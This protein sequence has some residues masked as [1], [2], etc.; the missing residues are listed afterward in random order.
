MKRILLL[1]VFGVTVIGMLSADPATALKTYDPFRIEDP[2]SPYVLDLS[3]TDSRR[4]R[5]IPVRI[6]LPSSKEPAAVALFSHGLGGSCKINAF[7]GNHWAQRGYAAVFVQ[8]PGSDSS[9]WKDVPPDKRMAALRKAA[10]KKNFILRAKDIPAVLN[11]LETWNQTKDHTFYKRFDCDHIGMSGHSFGAMTTQAVSGQAVWAGMQVFTDKRI[12]AAI[13]FSPSSPRSGKPEKAFAKVSIPWMLMTG[14][15]DLAA[16]GN[17]DMESRL[18]VFPSLPPGDKYEVVLFNA[19][20]SAFTDRALPGDTELRN[21]NHH[22]II[23]ALSTAFWDA[24]LNND[25]SAKTWLEGDGPR[26]VMEEQ[27]RWQKK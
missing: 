4:K 19:E 1:G 27:D 24:Y 8:H 11:E 2:N 6:Y 17:V 16:I 23:L 10:D 18:A 22:K 20:H 25:I 12:K 15:K 9:V 26:L 13:V 3:V 14:T 21:P 5:D 7:M